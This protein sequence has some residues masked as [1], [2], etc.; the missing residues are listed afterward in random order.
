MM[1]CW[2]KSV[3]EYREVNP[4]GLAVAPSELPASLR[5]V[6]A[7]AGDRRRLA[8]QDVGENVAAA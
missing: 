4:G 2:A 7:H 3:G 6:E 1:A 5:H 8:G